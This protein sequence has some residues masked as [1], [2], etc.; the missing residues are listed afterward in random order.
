MT[1]DKLPKD[2][3]NE[4]YAKCEY[5]DICQLSLVDRKWLNLI[6]SLTNETF[7][8]KRLAQEYS[9][10]VKHLT[11]SPPKSL[12]ASLKDKL[13]GSGS[14]RITDLSPKNLYLKLKKNALP[15]YVCYDYAHLQVFINWSTLK[16]FYK[17]SPID[18][19]VHGSYLVS[20][21]GSKSDT[22]YLVTYTLF[23]AEDCDESFAV[24]L[25]HKD[26]LAHDDDPTII[27]CYVKECQIIWR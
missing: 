4:I 24:C 21:S 15:V 5:E 2:I 23:G 27:A 14:E 8:N 9:S 11:P 10:I 6:K 22:A 13:L 16:E 1:L 3:L 17:N 12:F 19:K 25:R 18:P 7:W 20:S 26:A